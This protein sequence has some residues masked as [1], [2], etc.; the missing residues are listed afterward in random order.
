[1]HIGEDGQVKLA[2]HFVEDLQPRI[3]A[4]AAHGAARRTVGFVERAF[5][6]QGDAQ[7]RAYFFQPAC[8]V[9]GHFQTFNRTRACDQ[10]EGLVQANVKSAKFHGVSCVLKVRLWGAPCVPAQLS[11]KR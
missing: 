9:D 8:H 1:M 4:H 3:H 11:R 6:D 5:V 10:K 7:A 2:T